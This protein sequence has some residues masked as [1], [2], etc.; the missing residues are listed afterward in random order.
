MQHA[1]L[2]SPVDSGL[3][4]GVNTATQPM[5]FRSKWVLVTG[6]SSGLGL[7]IARQLALQH[8][9]NLILAARRE[10]RLLELKRELEASAKVQVE[11]V[12]ADL[13]QMADVDRLFE[14]ATQ[15][16]ELYAAV[17]NAGVTHFGR[18]DDLAWSDFERMLATNVQSVVRMSGHLVPYFER[19][20]QGGGFLIV[21]SMAGIVPVAFQTAY[22]GT[23]GFLVNFGCALHH[24]LEGRNVSVST[25]VPG[26]IQT[27]MTG[28][29]NFNPLRGWLMAVEPCARSAIEA[30]QTRRYLTAPGFTN[31]LGSVVTRFLPQRFVTGRVA[32]TYR[33]ALAKMNAAKPPAQT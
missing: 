14:T 7:H 31:R 5:N 29:E 9:A 4:R 28:G 24:E 16:R 22:S 33:S 15:G 13:S 12:T 17:L 11:T 20:N 30:L 10:S 25:F 19:L 27:E 6:A 23:K 32:A 2:P 21:S 26:G 18:H 8:G 1:S 3:R